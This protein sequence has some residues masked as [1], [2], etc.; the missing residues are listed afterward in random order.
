[1]NPL[2]MLAVVLWENQLK[3]IQ[4]VISSSP[5]STLNAHG[6]LNGRNSQPLSFK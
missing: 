5:G 6:F 4:G 3:I 1:M 2:T